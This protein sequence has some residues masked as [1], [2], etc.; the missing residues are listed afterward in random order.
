M[1]L[2]SPLLFISSNG[3]RALQPMTNLYVY[4]FFM[5]SVSVLV[6]VLKR[7][8]C[9]FLQAA[10]KLLGKFICVLQHYVKQ[11]A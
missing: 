10:Y 7:A 11:F 9:S 3:T 8:L 1:V 5:L 6:C 4:L 2:G